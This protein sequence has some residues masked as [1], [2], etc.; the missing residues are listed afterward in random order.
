[1]YKD[2]INKTKPEF[3]KAISFLGNEMMKI[4]TGRASTALVDDIV[5]DYLG[6]KYPLKQLASISIPEP[7]MLVIHPWDKSYLEPIQSAVVNSNIGANPIADKDVLRIILP[8]MSDEY[9]KNLTHVISEKT[10][11]VKR[12]IRHY[13]EEA[14]KQ[15][16]EG[17][18]AGTIREDDKFRA[19]DELQKVVDEFNK[20]ADDMAE[21]KK[22]EIMEI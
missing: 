19:K 6:S 12:T 17:T 5:V 2:I 20:K 11:E 21:K 9:R 3:E 10:E 22:K 1:M 15:I 18:K 4:R 14:W 7:R 8:P 13:R 16:Q